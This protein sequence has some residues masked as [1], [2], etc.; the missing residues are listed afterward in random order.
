MIPP[1]ALY[2][3]K[4]AFVIMKRENGELEELAFKTRFQAELFVAWLPFAMME[5]E[6][7]ADVRGAWIRSSIISIN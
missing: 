3:N 1:A 7:L 6:E 4:P 5:D 2:W